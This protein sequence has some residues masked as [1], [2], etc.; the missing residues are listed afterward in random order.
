M[1][2]FCVLRFITDSADIEYARLIYVFILVD[3]LRQQEGLLFL[4][5]RSLQKIVK[6]MVVP[7]ALPNRNDSAFLQQVTHNKG[8]FYVRLTFTIQQQ[9][10]L[11]KA[12]RVIVSNCLSISKGLKDLIAP[13][14]LVLD[15]V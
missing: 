4:S 7:L 15:P 2:N 3:W 14:D 12:R 8:T 10:Q 6:N 5:T 13:E 9:N 11:T 1:L